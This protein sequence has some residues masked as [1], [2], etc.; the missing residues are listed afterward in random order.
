MRVILKKD[1][2]NVGSKGD[3]V[4][5][6]PGFGRNYLIPKQLALEVTS[7][8]MKMIEIERQALKK[9]L[10]KE[11]QSFE[12]LIQNLNQV[13]LSFERKS[14][15]KDMIFGS[16]SSSDIKDALHELGFEIDKKKILLEEP[17]KR[18]GNYSVPIKIFQED[19]VEIKVEVI[20]PEG[21]M[22]EEKKEEEV[23]EEKM[24]EAGEREKP[25]EEQKKEEVPEEKKDEQEKTPEEQ[26]KEDEAVR[27]EPE[28]EKEE[29]K[30]EEEIPEEKREEIEEESIK[31]EVEML[32]KEE[33]EVL[34]EKKEEGEMPLDE[35]EKAEAGLERKEKEGQK[36]K[37][38]EEGK[39]K[40]SKK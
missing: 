16:V 15:E 31:P 2:E 9:K 14:G 7:S 38:K 36:D 30:E 20:K 18:L 33:K 3:I 24:E 10:E 22:G 34:E 27:K 28:G 29:K 6:A 4:D 12:G 32:E 17:I 40:R 21:E 1:V 37:K 5:V 19:K 13:A 8:N 35:E 11:R 23:P 39:K 26:L 25:E